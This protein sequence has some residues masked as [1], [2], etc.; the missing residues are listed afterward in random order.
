MLKAEE[1]TITGA[2]QAVLKQE[3]YF[4]RK[5]FSNGMVCAN[6]KKIELSF[7]ISTGVSN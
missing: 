3:K 1:R 4:S 5:V 7:K 6:G 2:A